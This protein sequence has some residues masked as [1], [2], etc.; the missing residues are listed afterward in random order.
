MGSSSGIVEL[1]C[2]VG[3]SSGIVEWDCRV[4]L[5]S[6]Q[7]TTSRLSQGKWDCRVGWSSCTRLR[8]DYFNSALPGGSGMVEWDCRVV[9]DSPQPTTSRLSQGEVGSSSGIVEL[10]STPRSRLQ[11]GSPRGKW[12][13][14]VGSSSGTRLP[15]ADYKSAL[16]GEV[17]WSSGIVELYSTPRSRLQ[18]GSPRRKS[19]RPGGPD[20]PRP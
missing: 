9:L 14:R 15:E 3:L 10:Y 8:V 5:D 12:D 13:C 7:P 1:D 17:G 6:S 11:V 16:P 2:R 18:V 20:P 19:D 4:V